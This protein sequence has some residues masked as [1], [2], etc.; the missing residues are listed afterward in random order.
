[1]GVPDV[2]GLP[3]ERVVDPGMSPVRARV[4]PVG[5]GALMLGVTVPG[6]AAVSEGALVVDPIGGGQLNRIVPEL[7]MGIGPGLLATSFDV[8][9]P[10]A[11]GPTALAVMPGKVF[12]KK[13]TGKQ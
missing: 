7:P 12:G 6:A 9:V 5:R 8:P 4:M 2:I 3:P 11:G 10:Q 13:P 1:M